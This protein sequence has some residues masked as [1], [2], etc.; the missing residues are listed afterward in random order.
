MCEHDRI[1]D[2]ILK[3]YDCHI[4]MQSVLSIALHG[5]LRKGVSHAIIQFVHFFKE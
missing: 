3:S 2:I 4:L 1:Q 5:V